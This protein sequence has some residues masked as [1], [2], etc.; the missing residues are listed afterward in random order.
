MPLMTHAQS[1]EDDVKDLTLCKT[2][3]QYEITISFMESTRSYFSPN[4]KE[5]LQED[6]DF[7]NQKFTNDDARKF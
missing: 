1:I 5:S 4:S 7:I 2:Q 3:N 6:G